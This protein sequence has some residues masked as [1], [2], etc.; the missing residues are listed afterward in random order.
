MS[1]SLES[2]APE[3]VEEEVASD[4]DEIDKLTDMAIAAADI[5]KYAFILFISITFAQAT[6][7]E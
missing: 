2:P 3:E 6:N 1:R 4:F 5:K 7:P